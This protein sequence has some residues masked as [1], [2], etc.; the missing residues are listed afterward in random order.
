MSCSWCWELDGV[1]LETFFSEIRAI[2]DFFSP[3]C[4]LLPH[5]MISHQHPLSAKPGQP[6]SDPGIEGDSEG[7]ES[8]DI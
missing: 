7:R 4:L 5:V 2:G 1:N 3:T 8:T 6:R